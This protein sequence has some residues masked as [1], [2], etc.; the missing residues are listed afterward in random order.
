[1][2]GAPRIIHHNDNNDLRRIDGGPCDQLPFVDIV[3]ADHG[4]FLAGLHD[5]AAVFPTR[6]CAEAVSARSRAPP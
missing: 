3:E 5:D 6:S 2:T 1:M 4:G